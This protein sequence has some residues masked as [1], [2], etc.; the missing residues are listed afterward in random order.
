MGHGALDPLKSRLMKNKNIRIFLCSLTPKVNSDQRWFQA[1]LSFKKKKTLMS[2]NWVNIYYMHVYIFHKAFGLNMRQT[3]ETTPPR[4]TGTL[5]NHLLLTVSIG[6]WFPNLYHGK[7]VVSLKHLFKK[8]VGF[9]VP[10]S[11][12]HGN[13]KAPPQ[14]PPQEIRP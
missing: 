12:Y 14:C 2:S 6:W 9:G 3:F 11:C 7:M 1:T 10:G 4:E 8:M 5:N 13:S